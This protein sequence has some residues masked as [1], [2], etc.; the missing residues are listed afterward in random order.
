MYKISELARMG[1]VSV[2]TLHHYDAIGLLK[3][4]GH[5]EGGYRLYSDEDAQ[6]LQQ[7]LFFREL[8]FPLKEIK[9]IIEDPSFD[10]DKALLNHRSLLQKKAERLQ[11]LL[12]TI[13]YT[14]A[15]NEGNQPVDGKKLFGGFNMEDMKEYQKKYREEAAGKYG[16]KIVAQAEERTSRYTD[17][18]WE[19][20]QKGMNAIFRKIAD[21]MEGGPESEEVQQAVDEWRKFI[22]DHYYDCTPD[23]FRGLAD[24]YTGDERFRHNIDQ[25]KPGLAAFMSDA[26]IIYC[27]RLN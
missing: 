19:N 13:D 17:E 11:Q 7:I 8:G 9:E 20:N 5:S 12:A 4:S 24:V 14:L 18:D 16:E 10:R 2:R 6:T 27:D 26:I 15:V 22:T 1:S 23:I 21:G 3:P 25:I